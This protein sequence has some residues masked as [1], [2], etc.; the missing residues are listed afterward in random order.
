MSNEHAL[1]AA[2]MDQFV[3]DGYLR[4]DGAFS[5]QL[6]AECR[7]ILWRDTGCDPADPSTWRQPVIRLGEH[8][9]PPFRSAVNTPMLHGAFDSL[10]GETRWLPRGSL[11]TFPIRFPSKVD[12]GDC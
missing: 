1:D 5:K 11:G 3:E 7:E 8:F 12:P 9:E 2:Q 6:A 4:L 10:I